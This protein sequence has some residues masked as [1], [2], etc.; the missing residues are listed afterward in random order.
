MSATVEFGPVAVYDGIEADKKHAVKIIEEAA[1]VLG[2]WQ[3]YDKG[4]VGDD[5]NGIRDILDECCD[6]VTAV[7]N[8]CAALGYPN[9]VPFM[10]D[11]RQ[12]NID[13]GNIIEKM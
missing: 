9:M 3:R 10:E 12:K 8:F 4:Q 5:S 11:C 2:A 6:V 7:G 13:R 1:E